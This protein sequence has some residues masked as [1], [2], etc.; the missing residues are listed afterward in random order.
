[1]PGHHVYDRSLEVTIKSQFFKSYTDASGYEYNLYYVVQWKGS[2]GDDTQWRNFNCPFTYNN[3]KFTHV[4]SNSD[5]TVVS[6]A[7]DHPSESSPITSK[8]PAGSQL[9]FRVEA[10]IGHFVE[11]TPLD[12]MLGSHEPY[13]VRDETSG[14]SSIQTITLISGS[15]SPSSSQTAALPSTTSDSNS[16]QQYP[17]QTQSPNSIFTNTF[18]M[19][20][21]GVILGGIVVSVVLVIFRRQP[22]TSQVDTYVELSP[23]LFSFLSI[24][25][26]RCGW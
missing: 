2:F 15:S 22:K 20:F 23:K 14:Y 6:S 25:L 17:K 7:I 21:V 16:Q 1:M 11:P 13:L 10:F 8:Y 3:G 18:F 12:H 26:V 5:Y 24:L 9:D 4:Q 19:L